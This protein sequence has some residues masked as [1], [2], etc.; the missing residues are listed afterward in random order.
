MATP[1]SANPDAPVTVCGNAN[2]IP[3]PISGSV[4]TAGVAQ[5]STTSGQTGTLVQGAVTTAAPT[6]TTGQTNPL[7]LTTTGALRVGV[8]GNAGASLDGT[9][10]A[11]TAP[12]NGLGLLGV[13]Q[14]NANQSAAT[15]GQSSGLQTDPAGNL[16]TAPQRP[17][18]TDILAGRQTF[19][20]TTGATTLIT[21]AAGRT[22]VGY[23]GASV[24]CAEVAAGTAAPIATATFTTAGTNVVPAAG[25]YAVVDARA[26]AN[27]AT[28]VV[29]DGCANFGSYVW[30]VVAPAGNS[31]T[32]Q[33]ASTNAGTT[34]LVEAAAYGVMQ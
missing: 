23:I 14:N 26:G 22:W 7:S 20:S 21:V 31:V 9:L 34:S 3:I 29:G 1:Q 4:T 17:T 12:T 32:I 18:A 16:R 6:Y 13:Y 19:T 11:G 15:T 28:G 2:G 27:A 5:G 25:T 10:A 8:V 24:S 30:T 33:V